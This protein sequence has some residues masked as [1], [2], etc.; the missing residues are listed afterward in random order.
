MLKTVIVKYKTALKTLFFGICL[1]I[2]AI[3]YAYYSGGKIF[4]EL[5]LI[6]HSNITPGSLVDTQKSESEDSYGNVA[7]DYGAV[8]IFHTNN[9]EEFKSY[10]DDTNDQKVEIEYLPENPSV[11][12]VKG[13]GCTSVQ[14]WIWRKIVVGG[15]ILAFLLSPGFIVIKKGIKEIKITKKEIQNEA[16]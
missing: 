6:R 11:N 16:I 3:W 4:D 1:I 7:V 12:R 13:Y 2:I 5:A 15:V 14:D 9:G 8:Y 10:S